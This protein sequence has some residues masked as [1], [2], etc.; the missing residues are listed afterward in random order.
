MSVSKAELLQVLEHRNSEIKNTVCNIHINTCKG[1]LQKPPFAYSESISNDV[2]EG[3][4]NYGDKLMS[5]AIPEEDDHG[6][7]HNNLFILLDQGWVARNLTAP[8]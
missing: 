4:V 5:N 8:L 7:M 3:I 1:I 6:E 2:A